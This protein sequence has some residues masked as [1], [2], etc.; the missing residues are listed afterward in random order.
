M[1]HFMA[2]IAM[3]LYL[4]RDK[5]TRLPKT[6]KYNYDNLTVNPKINVQNTRNAT[7]R[8]FAPSATSIAYN[9]HNDKRMRRKGF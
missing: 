1:F 2:I 7:L 8:T 9:I 5:T 4:V 6:T 3:I